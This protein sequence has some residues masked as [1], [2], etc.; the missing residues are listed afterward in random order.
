VAVLRV[1]YSSS[2]LKWSNPPLSVPRIGLNSLTVMVIAVS[3]RHLS[4]LGLQ[5]IVSS[6][7]RGPERLR[8]RVEGGVEGGAICNV[9]GVQFAKD[10]EKR[11]HG[12]SGRRMPHARLATTERRFYT[13]GG[14]GACVLQ[15][16]G[17]WVNALFATWARLGFCRHLSFPFSWRA[18]LYPFSSIIASPYFATAIALGPSR[19]CV[20]CPPADRR[21]RG[22]EG[23]RALTGARSE[24]S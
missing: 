13:D 5:L 23:C 19:L 7:W 2:R 16:C 3:Y 8:G 21:A 10:G 1:D 9:A 15:C 11:G 14:T 12:K 17:R 4:R 18:G 24:R 20:V 6:S 22:T